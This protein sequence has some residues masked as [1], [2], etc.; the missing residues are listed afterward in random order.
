MQ[1]FVVDLR[2]PAGGARER[3]CSARLA[4]YRSMGNA[5]RHWLDLQRKLRMGPQRDPQSFFEWVKFRS[6]YRVV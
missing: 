3:A 2:L 4:D 1:Q 5:Q 6:H